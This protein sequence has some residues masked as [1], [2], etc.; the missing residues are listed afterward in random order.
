MFLIRRPSPIAIERFLDD[1]RGL[2]LSYGPV[3][4]V[5]TGT[6]RRY[7]DDEAA[8]IGRGEA[9]FARARRALETWQQFDIGWAEL[10]PVLAP[11]ITGTVVA[12][13][14][15]HF[16]FWSMHGCRVVHLGDGEPEQRFGRMAR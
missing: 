5:K 10:F 3:G 1:S 7:F 9:D 2:P 11:P 6:T 13:L 12:V 15:S 16:G 8:T 4:I 14:A